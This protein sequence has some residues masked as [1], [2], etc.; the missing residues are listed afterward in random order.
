MHTCRLGGPDPV[1]YISMYSHPGDP[2]TDTPMHWH[3]ITYGLSDLHGDNRVHEWVTKWELSALTFFFGMRSVHIPH[4]PQAS[5]PA[6]THTHAHMHAHTHTHTNTHTHTHTHTTHATH[7]HTDTHWSAP[8]SSSPL[9][10]PLTGCLV[11]EPRVVLDLSWPFDWWDI[12]VMMAHPPGLLSSCKSFQNMCLILVHAHA[13]HHW[14]TVKPMKL[15]SWQRPLQLTYR[16]I[17][18]VQRLHGFCTCSAQ[19]QLIPVV[20]LFTLS[21]GYPCSCRSSGVTLVWLE[22]FHS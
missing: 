19:E 2:A 6:R 21:H 8:L 18:V 12:P 14:Y 3:Y 4:T 13:N 10:V 17:S 5:T 9:Y 11:Q 22:W 7:R 20:T 16:T 1:D 15:C